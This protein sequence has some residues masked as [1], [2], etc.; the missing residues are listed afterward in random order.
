MRAVVVG[1]H[2][3]EGGRLLENR[4]FLRFSAH[5]GFRIRACRAGR[6]QT[7]GKVERPIRYVR[8]SFFYGPEF[9]SDDDLNARARRWL[10][11][12][13][14]VRVHSALK[15]RPVARLER[16]HRQQSARPHHRGQPTAVSQR[17]LLQ[18]HSEMGQSGRSYHRHFVV[19]KWEWIAARKHHL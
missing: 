15:Q 12:V 11:T 8:S 13:A 5:C 19:D 2:R 1:D 14:N 4:E 16:L 10:D 18:V 7:K 9:V 6:A 3:S 17:A